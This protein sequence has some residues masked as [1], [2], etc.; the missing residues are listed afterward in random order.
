MYATFPPDPDPEPA[1]GSWWT[2][3]RPV[4]NGTA[5]AA[6]LA[7]GEWWGQALRHGQE[8]GHA[9]GAWFTAIALAACG[10]GM[11]HVYR[12]FTVRRWLARVAL[13]AAL[14]GLV[15]ALPVVAATVYLITGVAA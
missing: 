7:P 6:A 11:V 5:L 15:L 4:Y 10:A 9:A 3:L 14:L 12:A 2:P 1:S 13:F 8:Q